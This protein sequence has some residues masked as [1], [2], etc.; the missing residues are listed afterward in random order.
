MKKGNLLIWLLVGGAAVYLFFTLK[1]DGVKPIIGGIPPSKNEAKKKAAALKNEQIAALL[2]SF[3]L[4]GKGSEENVEFRDAV[5]AEA[6][7]RKLSIPK[8]P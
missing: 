3:C 6:L 8:C 7:K 4:V 2:V 1:K 5:R